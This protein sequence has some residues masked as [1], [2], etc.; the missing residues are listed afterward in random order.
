MCWGPA[1]IVL[2]SW[3]CRLCNAIICEVGKGHVL[4]R[5]SQ[6][7]REKKVG[8]WR[9]HPC[10]YS[11]IIRLQV[12]F[13]I[14]ETLLMVR[15]T[16]MRSQSVSVLMDKALWWGVLRKWRQASMP[17]VMRSVSVE[18]LTSS[19]TRNAFSGSCPRCS[20]LL[21][22]WEVSF[23]NELRSMYYAGDGLQIVNTFSRLAIAGNNK[24]LCLGL[25]VIK[26]RLVSSSMISMIS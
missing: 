20:S 23:M 24:A 19:V 21:R 11:S 6:I 22:K 8:V 17:F 2:I 26:K 15:I 3:K 16:R 13:V 14:K 18:R 7:W 25:V 10:P 12:M 9:S 4:R 5:P 1:L